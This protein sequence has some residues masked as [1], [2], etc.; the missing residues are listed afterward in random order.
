MPTSCAVVVENLERLVDDP[1]A[2]QQRIDRA[3]GLGSIIQPFSRS[4]ELI[5]NGAISS[6]MINERKRGENFCREVGEG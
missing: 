5:Q 3:V 4:G 2:L 1:Q 6:W